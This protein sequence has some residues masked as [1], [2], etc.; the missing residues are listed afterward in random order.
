[1]ENDTRGTGVRQ[2]GTGE[3]EREELAREI[4]QRCFG[5]LRPFLHKL[6]AQLDRRLVRTLA[7]LVPVLLGRRDRANALLLSELGDALGGEGH[8]PA[9]T[10]RVANLLHSDHWRARD[11]GAFLR[12]RAK[13]VAVAEAARVPEGRALLILDGSV[14]EKP[15]SARLEGLAPVVSAKGRRLRRPR[16]KLG[17]GY[18]RG[19]PGP[20][21]VVPG[22]SW[23]GAL[24]TGWAGREARRPVAL[25][26]WMWY[27]RVAHDHPD[28][29]ALEAPVPTAS[30]GAAARSLLHEAVEAIGA[31]RLLFV[32]DREY[33]NTPWLATLIEERVPFVVRWK[34]GNHLRPE[35]APSVGDPLASLHQCQAEGRPAWRL[36]QKPLFRQTRT[37]ANP[38]DPKTPIPVTFGARPVRLVGDDTPL[39]LVVV[40]VGKGGRRRRHGEPWRLVTDLPLETY[41]GVWRVVEAYAARWQIE[42]ML[43]F[44][45]AELGVESVRARGWE[46]RAKLLAL[47]SLAYAALVQLLGDGASPLVAEVL[48][49]IHRTGRQ[50]N[51]AWRPLYRFRRALAALF[52]R[53]TP[54]FQ[55]VP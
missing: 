2:G 48:R 42:Q 26:G 11:V 36:G 6:D 25:G 7:N 24:V 43:R 47:L 10:K 23:L 44:S 45:K 19:K 54:T 51:H 16:P 31:A 8:G 40:R 9:G 52:K 5:F 53:H 29:D 22:F 28:Q 17:P 4:G 37:I 20:P 21:T 30:Q 39:W 14:Q 15:E 38:R 50:A 34:K 55:G 3:G 35:E 41:E 27:R 13:D 46:P 12:G 1:M 49:L 18:W 33:A 32:G